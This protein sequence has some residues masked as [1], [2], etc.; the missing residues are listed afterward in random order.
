MEKGIE[1]KLMVHTIFFLHRLGG[2]ATAVYTWHGCQ[3][4]LQGQTEVAYTSNDSPMII[5]LNNHVALEQMR[6]KADKTGKREMITLS[7]Y[8]GLRE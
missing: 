1:I 4:T 7:A 2:Q 6:E 5:Y 8:K 3:V